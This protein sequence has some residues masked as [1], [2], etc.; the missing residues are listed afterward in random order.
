MNNVKCFDIG[1]I[2]WKIVSKYEYKLP[3]NVQ[4]FQI[5]NITG[6][7]KI[8]EVIVEDE[9][10]CHLNLIDQDCKYSYTNWIEVI[11]RGDL[12]I[13]SYSP[14]GISPISKLV[15]ERQCT[16]AYLYIN[17]SLYDYD[18]M[19]SL[20][21]STPFLMLN[22]LVQLDN[23]GF[24]IHTSA[25]EV[26]N[27]GAL[28]SGESGS[29]KT[30]LT[31]LMNKYSKNKILTDETAIIR[32]KG[33]IYFVYGTPWKGSGAEYYK[34]DFGE[35]K[36]ISFI[37]HGK[38]NYMKSLTRNEMIR[39]TMKQSFP[40]FWDSHC[41]TRLFAIVCDLVNSIEV[42]KLYFLPNETVVDYIEEYVRELK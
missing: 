7:R 12:Q 14:D 11:K 25:F 27:K 26:Q 29:G 4:E 37:Y 31:T 40:Y 15:Y 20:I 19:V 17:D 24:L 2:V 39:N 33:N 22:M 5:A 36:S 23:D 9:K 1:G 32:K 30:T 8:I 6:D 21:E 28:F 3:E 16:T 34:N 38:G 18:S 35:L 42:N 41:M 10:N 13:F